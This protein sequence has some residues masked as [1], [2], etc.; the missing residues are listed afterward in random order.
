MFET[1]LFAVMEIVESDLNLLVPGGTYP[2][3]M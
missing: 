1:L 2:E 3:V